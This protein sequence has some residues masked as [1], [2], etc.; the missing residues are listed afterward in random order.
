MECFGDVRCADPSSFEF[1]HCFG[2]NFL[3]LIKESAAD[4][5]V[6]IFSAI[7]ESP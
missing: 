6:G 5:T 2:L 3:L 4:W 1:G 7:D